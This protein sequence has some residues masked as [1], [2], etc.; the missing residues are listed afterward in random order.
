[1][2]RTNFNVSSLI[3]FMEVKI[4]VYKRAL[5]LLLAANENR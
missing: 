4:D 3:V 1:M 5:S 2:G